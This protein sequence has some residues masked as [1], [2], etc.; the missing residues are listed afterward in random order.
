MSGKL[1]VAWLS[2]V[3]SRG[4]ASIVKHLAANDSETERQLMNSVVD[5]RVFREVYLLPFEMAARPAHGV[6]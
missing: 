4:V 3:Q 5:E 6:P 2:G 1:A